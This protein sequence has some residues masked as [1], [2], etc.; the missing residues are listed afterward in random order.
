VR[1]TGL[2]TYEAVVVFDEEKARDISVEIE[3]EGERQ[4]LHLTQQYVTRKDGGEMVSDD[5]SVRVRFEKNGVYQTLF[6][7]VVAD[8]AEVDERMV[9]PAFRVMPEDVAFERAE[10]AFVYPVDH[11]DVGKLGI[12]GWNDK[13]G[14]VFVDMGRDS[15]LGAVTGEVKHFGLFAMLIDNVPPEITEVV[16]KDGAA[17]VE[18]QPKV[19]ATVR[20]VSSGI[21]REED[22]A[23]RIDG[24]ALIVEY[25]P[26]EDL[27]F[28][29]PRKPLSSGKHQLE[30][31]VR[32][33]CGNESRSRSA[34]QVK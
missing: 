32:D 2:L 3:A 20:D 5:G 33:I 7:R 26:E 31:M 17:V 18:R 21:W 1:Q 6:G 12:Y 16:P 8:S 11:P 15:V 30:V 9:G 13:Q 28:A 34:F 19:F 27:I 4:F 29:I 14:W 10:L 23:M 24:Q 25:D 22:I